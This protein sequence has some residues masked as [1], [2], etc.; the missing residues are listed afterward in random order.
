MASLIFKTNPRTYMIT[1]KLT[2][3]G[4]SRNV[5]ISV[6]SKD[7]D[8]LCYIEKGID[9]V[10]T[11]ESIKGTG[12]QVNGKFTKRSKLKFGDLLELGHE[13]AVFL[14]T[15]EITQTGKEDTP[16]K[17]IDLLSENKELKEVS[18]L[19]LNNLMDKVH[20]EKGMVLLIENGEPII[21]VGAEKDGMDF[22]TGFSETIIKT[23]LLDKRP[24]ISNNVLNDNRFTP[25]RSIIA[26][27]IIATVVVPIIRDDITYGVVYLWNSDPKN[28]FSD[29][30]LAIVKFYA[31]IL[32]ILIENE[33]LKYGIHTTM[34]R[35]RINQQIRVWH[36]LISMNRVMIQVFEQCDKL[37]NVKSNVVFYGE[38]GTGKKSLVRAIY[39][40]SS[41]NADMYMIKLKDKPAEVILDELSILNSMNNTYNKF[42]FI[43]ID[44][45]E[46][47]PE[48]LQQTLNAIIDKLNYARWFFLME[49]HPDEVSS[50][51]KRIRSRLGEIIIRLPSLRER[52]EDIVP[53]A[54]RF[55]DQFSTMYS[56]EIK[57]FT[58]KAIQTLQGYKWIG[59]IEE[60]KNVVKKAVMETDSDFVEYDS[61]E[62]VPQDINFTPLAKAKS[63][64]M[65]R[66]IKAALESTNGDKLKAARMLKISQRTIYKYIDD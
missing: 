23:V 1:K 40:A 6:Q 58:Q 28:M 43:A 35:F 53:L 49:K 25:T 21:L 36:N 66:Y 46:Y 50:L 16:F 24:I 22:L 59:N 27:K 4:S 37:I 8:L 61:L 15:D 54:E 55:L 18:K 42:L 31:W 56:K 29:E 30:T 17:D 2:T 32:S 51:N 3:I 52:Q 13:L 26:L 20:A 39:E 7:N 41:N 48:E 34:K 11:I 62:I 45:L 63:D 9:D 33:K 64:F 38:S 47:M 60:L 19:I 65:K 14:D 44:G 10:Y 5:D 12:I 57:G